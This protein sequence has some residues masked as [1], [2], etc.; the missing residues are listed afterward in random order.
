MGL[1]MCSI[2]K[3]VG[4]ANVLESRCPDVGIYCCTP[5]RVVL[6]II[7]CNVLHMNA[8]MVLYGVPVVPGVRFA[9]VVRPG[10]LPSL[11]ELHSADESAGSG[12][13]CRNGFAFDAAATSAAETSRDAASDR[14]RGGRAHGP[15]PHWRSIARGWTPPQE[16][17]RKACRGSSRCRRRPIHRPLHPRSAA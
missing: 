4:S 7:W 14:C 16:H 2:R 17:R 1:H 8:P 5:E 10:R 11:D 12:L 9:P 3:C 13:R 6:S 15:R